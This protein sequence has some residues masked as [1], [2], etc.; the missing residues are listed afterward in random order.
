MQDPILV[1]L[2]LEP[3]GWVHEY[4]VV[5]AVH[6]EYVH[7]HTLVLWDFDAH[8]RQVPNVLLVVYCLLVFLLR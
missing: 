1:V 7:E 5:G 2:V 6:L 8:N 4:P 3:H